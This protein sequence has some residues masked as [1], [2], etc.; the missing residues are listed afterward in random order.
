MSTIISRLREPLSHQGRAS[1]AQATVL[2]CVVGAIRGISLVAFIPAALA[3][4]SSAPA[5]GLTALVQS[6]AKPT[7]LVRTRVGTEPARLDRCPR[8]LRPR[9]LRRRV[10]AVD[11]LL[12]GCLRLPDEHASRHR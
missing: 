8:R 3:L 11:A 1:F 5:W 2:S 7:D 9:L 4:T 6:P 10:P 12:L